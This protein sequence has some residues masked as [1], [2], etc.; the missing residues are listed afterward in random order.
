MTIPPGSYTLGPEQATLTVRTGRTGAASKAGHNLVIEVTSWS[1]E[2]HATED[3]AATEMRLSADSSSLQVLDG[4][5]GMQTLGDDDKVAIGK[6][7]NDEV[8]KR[9]V[10]EFR[11]SS[12]DAGRDAGELRV[13][14]EL[15]LLGARRPI[16]FE[17]RAGDDGNLTGRATITQSDF[18]IKPYSTLFG[19]LK[20]VDEVQ[21]AL[22]GHLPSS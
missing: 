6:T 10:I 17:L 12:V 21:V 7:I 2:L 3:P 13:H 19:A 1:A 5:G 18:G 4:T 20:V 8:L 11:S 14:G 22:D 15:D 16:I 9:G